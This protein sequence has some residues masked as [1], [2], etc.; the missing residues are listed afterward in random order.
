MKRFLALILALVMVFAL[1]ACSGNTEGDKKD[2]QKGSEPAAATKTYQFEGTFEEQGEFASM[3]NAAFLLNLNAD[4]TAV[5]DKYDF[6]K[7]DASDFASNPT[8]IQSYLS[9]TWKQVQ[10]DGVDCLQIKLAYKD[11]SGNESNGTT[12]YA[13]DVA[14]QY[15]FD[16]SYPVVPGQSY[17]RTA[18][19]TGKEGTLYADKNAFIQAH[20]ATFTAPEHIAQFKDEKG[21][22]AYLQTDGNMLVYGGYDKFA[23]GKWSRDAQGVKISIGG[24][25]VEVT[26]DGKKASFKVERTMGDNTMEYTL[27]C[28]DISVLPAP[29]VAENAPYTATVSM[30][31]RDTTAELTLNDDGTANFKV[32]T[33]MA[34]TYK[35][36]GSAVVLSADASKL[37]GYAAQI[38]PNV[39]HAFIINDD[40]SMKSI[41]NA[42]EAGSLALLLLD[43]TAMRVEFPSYKMAREG[44]TY[45][46]SEDGKTL[47]VTA[48]DAET[49]GAFSQ[50]WQAS[51]SAKWTITDNTAAKA[52]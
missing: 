13:Y 22:T 50:I 6:G 35:K 8:Y 44:F 30:G 31:G 15:S 9:G 48:P 43:D 1:A 40:H 4:G 21:N 46:L 33:N 17:T 39:S 20:K 42:Y 45:T 41:K 18:T 25:P 7:Y 27:T 47:N 38:W 37:E 19:M 34:C 24:T 12:N 5:V 36:I 2:E 28:D 10:K 23:E 14:G 3:L 32:F 26:S 11:A 29:Q 52:E 16:M 51:G 49:L